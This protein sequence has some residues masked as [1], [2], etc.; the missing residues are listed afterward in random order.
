ML[1]ESDTH[2]SVWPFHLLPFLSQAYS[3]TL[4]SIN[5]LSETTLILDTSQPIPDPYPYQ[6]HA[7]YSPEALSPTPHIQ[8][9]YIPC[10]LPASSYIFSPA[11]SMISSMQGKLDSLYTRMNGHWSFMKILT[12]SLLVTIHFKSHQL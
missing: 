11:L 4:T 5:Y 9:K 12:M 3:T 6:T 2:S 1:K 8:S 10:A 7:L